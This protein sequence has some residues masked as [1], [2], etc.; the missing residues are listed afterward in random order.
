MFKE[1]R[2]ATQTFAS[3]SRQFCVCFNDAKTQTVDVVIDAVVD[4]FTLFS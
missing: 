3:W 4:C 2:E 1:C